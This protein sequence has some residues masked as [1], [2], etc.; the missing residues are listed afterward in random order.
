MNEK[1]RKE[2][3]LC[4]NIITIDTMI[5]KTIGILENTDNTNIDILGID[6]VLKTIQD[7]L[8]IIKKYNIDHEKIKDIVN[9]NKSELDTE[10]QNALNEL[11]IKK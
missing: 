1:E 9:K 5:N 3:N 11:I 10:Q 2:L 8:N 4:L 7:K 6:A